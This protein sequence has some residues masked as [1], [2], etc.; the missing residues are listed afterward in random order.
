MSK[1]TSVIILIAIVAIFTM[2]V[3]NVY[4]EIFDDHVSFPIPDNVDKTEKRCSIKQVDSTTFVFGCDWKFKATNIEEWLETLLTE[5]ALVEPICV[6]ECIEEIIQEE[7]PSNFVPQEEMDHLSMYEEDLA[8]FEEDPPR[9]QTEED[10]YKLLKNY[11]ECKRAQNS[12]RGITQDDSFITSQTV[13]NPQAVFNLTIEGNIG[14]LLLAYEECLGQLN[15]Q[16]MFGPDRAE[17][18]IIG[19]EGY[20]GATQPYHAQFAKYDKEFWA[21]IPTQSDSVID[22]HDLITEQKTAWEKMCNSNKV[23]QAFKRDQ[24]CLE[25]PLPT[26]AKRSDGDLELNSYIMDQ[27]D[28]YKEYGDT[29]Q[30]EKILHDYK[31]AQDEARLEVWKADHD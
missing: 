29:E 25:T 2:G 30:L 19:K 24:G 31:R 3:N 21:K 20:F 27:L 12:A 11:T 1:W 14:R 26:T 22:E 7:I 17:G 16:I 18:E 28:R 8:E 9:T 23:V 15:F 13:I 4:G 5:T 6:E 10:Y